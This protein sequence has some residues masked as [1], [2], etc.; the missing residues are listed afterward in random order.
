MSGTEIRNAVVLVIDQLG[1][2]FLGAYGSTLF[3]TPNFNRLAAESLLFD[4]AI[5]ASPNLVQAYDQF[6]GNSEEKNWLETIG[7]AGYSPVLLSD[8]SELL[9]HDSSKYFDRILPFEKLNNDRPAG[10]ME[11]T[12]L[13][14]FFAQAAQ[15][16]ASL[17]NGSCLW[18]H[19][20]GL[21][22]AW[23]AP[24]ELRNQLANS[25]D[26]EPP[27]WCE[28]PSGWF[29]PNHDDPDQL[30]SYQQVCAAQVTL[31]DDF[32]GVVLDL[33]ETG[34]GKSTVLCLLSPR[35]YPLGEHGIVGSDPTHDFEQCHGESLHVPMMIRTPDREGYAS[36]RS[37]RSGALV[38]P[39]LVTQLLQDWFSGDEPMQEAL[40]HFAFQFPEK[41]KEVAWTKSGDVNA[42]Q[43]HAWKLIVE[44]DRTSLYVKPDDRWE[45]NDVSR[46]CPS[47][48]ESMEN[49]IKDLTESGVILWPEGYELSAELADR[50]E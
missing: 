43:T 33:M 8:A 44:G 39:S 31:I 50:Q 22:G 4:Q 14:H 9:L 34:L 1:A 19:S 38:Q 26:P 40:R 18:L 25:E 5:A 12:E 11:Q 16:I 6:W 27:H 47:I 48:V 46:R 15:A 24:L 35:G 7:E 23:D 2:N 10:G 41:N 37:L 17:E 28:P 29:D 36:F 45:V 32:L 49:V 13:A 30:L 21:S 20:S 42:L 3:E